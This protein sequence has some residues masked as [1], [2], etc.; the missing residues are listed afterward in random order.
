MVKAPSILRGL[1]PAWTVTGHMTETSLE[2]QIKLSSTYL[3]VLCEEGSQLC[4]QQLPVG[5][6]G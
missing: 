3:Q 6:G 2:G 4:L 5:E 1:E